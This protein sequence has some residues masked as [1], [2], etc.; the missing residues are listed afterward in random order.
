[1]HAGIDGVHIFFF[2]WVKDFPE[3]LNIFI[4]ISVEFFPVF[5]VAPTKTPAASPRQST[6]GSRI[7]YFVF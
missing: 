3:F 2:I 7:W 1:V 5:K 6:M 4:Y